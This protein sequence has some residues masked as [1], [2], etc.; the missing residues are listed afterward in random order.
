MIKGR[1]GK[2]TLQT[3]QSSKGEVVELLVHGDIITQFDSQDWVHFA[4]A[5]IEFTNNLQKDA[6][7][8]NSK[9]SLPVRKKDE[10]VA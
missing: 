3:S 10:E 4:R 5:Y 6:E 9:K 8:A 7:K 2:F 1:Y